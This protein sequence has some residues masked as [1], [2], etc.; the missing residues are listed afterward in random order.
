[1]DGRLKNVN[2]T[3]DLFFFFLTFQKQMFIRAYIEEECPFNSKVF[4]ALSDEL[5]CFALTRKKILIMVAD[6]V[7]DHKLSKKVPAQNPIS[8]LHTIIF[9]KEIPHWKKC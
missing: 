8:M 4:H 6:D 7:T 3:V 1:M 9:K 5:L 2:E